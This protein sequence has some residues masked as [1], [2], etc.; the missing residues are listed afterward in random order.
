MVP[1]NFAYFGQTDLSELT[2]QARI[3]EHRIKYSIKEIFQACF[4]KPTHKRIHKPIHKPI[5][6][7]LALKTVEPIPTRL[8]FFPPGLRKPSPILFWGVW[9]KYSQESELWQFFGKINAVRRYSCWSTHL[10]FLP[11]RLTRIY[12]HIAQSM[13]SSTLHIV[14]ACCLFAHRAFGELNVPNPVYPAAPLMKLENNVENGF[15]QDFSLF[16][17]L[18]I[19]FVQNIA[20][21][22]SSTRSK[23]SQVMQQQLRL[24]VSFTFMGRLFKW[25]RSFIRKLDLVKLSTCIFFDVNFRPTVCS[26]AKEFLTSSTMDCPSK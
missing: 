24:C 1:L 10:I 8:G 25:E 23:K 12:Y 5:H 16:P 2:L 14:G 3:L 17:W 21:A 20:P 11:V 4:H 22:E 18:K 19:I 7:S 9:G 26:W 13:S 15:L 6:K